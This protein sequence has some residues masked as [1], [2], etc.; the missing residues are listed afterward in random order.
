ML[1][2]LID[3]VFGPETKT[4]DGDGKMNNP[5]IN[6]V[7]WGGSFWTSDKIEA[8]E[9]AVTQVVT[10]PFP[11]VTNEYGADGRFMFLNDS[12]L[13]SSDPPTNFKDDQI[14][15]VIQNQIDSGHFPEPD[16]QQNPFV[17]GGAGGQR[18]PIYVCITPPGVK[19]SDEPND[20]G[21]NGVY[22][23]FDLPFD[24]DSIGECWVSGSDNI[25]SFSK[26]FSHEIAEIMTDFEDIDSN[27]FQLQAGSGFTGQKDIQIAD[28]E[29]QSYKF[30]MSNGVVV[31][32]VWSD[33]H[34][35]YEVNDGTSQVFNLK[36][37]GSEFE[38]TV[39][40]D[41]LSTPGDDITLGTDAAG[42]LAITLNGESINFDKDYISGLTLNTGAGVNTITFNG[43]PSGKTLKV[44][45]AGGTILLYGPQTT[46]NRWVIN[47]PGSVLL[48]NGNQYNF[49]NISSIVGRAHGGDVFDFAPGGSLSGFLDADGGALDYSPYGAPMTLDLGR[50][51][52]TGI[53][54][55][56][57]H[58]ANVLG[59]G[60]SGTLMANGGTWTIDGP[61]S[62]E[63]SGVGFFS[64]GNLAG[65]GG[66]DTFAFTGGS[67]SG[68]LD[69]GGGTNTLDY[70][71][72][73]GPI[74]VNFNTHTA[75]D[76]GGTFAN[77]QKVIGSMSK[78]DSITGPHSSWIISGADS[79]TVDNITWVSFENLIG[80]TDPDTFTFLDGGSISGNLDGGG[81]NDVL[82]YSQYTGPVTLDLADHTATGIGGT[83]SDITG[84]VGGQGSNTIVGPSGPTTWTVT[85]VD[86]V[87]AAGFTF[88]NFPSI[89]GGPSNDTINFLPDGRLDGTID[90]GGG[91][92]TVS[93]ASCTGDTIVNLLLHTAPRVAQGIFNVQNVIAGNGNCLLVGDGGANA[94]TGGT[95]RSILIGDAGA[96]TLTGGSGDN[97]LIGGSTFYDNNMIALMAIFSEW[98]RTDL[99]F[100]R[101]FAD[102]VS[103]NPNGLNGGYVLTRST[104]LSDASADVLIG[105]AGLD[106]FFVT[107]KQDSIASGLTPGDR[108]T[109]L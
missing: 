67:L 55:I 4:D 72:L 32:S 26:I 47:G 89:N 43:F 25:D 18:A 90:G 93:Y 54:G 13:D 88:T 106:W 14:N 99:S 102:L 5:P 29:A 21:W 37:Q 59:S 20:T 95:G 34:Q 33:K 91:T 8:V 7:F 75:S 10:S 66:N 104:V 24:L 11:L 107:N 3:P 23:D 64:F 19:S 103:G 78:K 108:T 101:R 17:N 35:A 80:T 77:I 97:I 62:G 84:F 42:G 60:T 76:I 27:G 56:F 28:N 48:S 58:V 53:G 85:G 9:A 51:E 98:T 87:S 50:G 1:T 65:E 63:V 73:A 74:S 39:N 79:G 83:F 94:L 61:D 16:D 69:G 40:G 68:N 105:S 70:S 82:D 15:D 57:E 31:Q 6:L 41:Q 22:H 49:S 46:Q 36:P 92:N 52:A 44:N 100:D 30:R 86:T 45:G 38:L 109:T 81:G 71:A 12:Y 2:I 96:D